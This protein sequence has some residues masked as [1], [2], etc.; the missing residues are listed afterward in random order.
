MTEDRILDEAA[1]WFARQ[2]DDAMDWE[3]FTAWLEADPCHRQAFDELCALDS[4]LYLHG[5]D[6]GSGFSDV[7]GSVSKDAGLRWGR[8]AGL[9]GAVAAA[10][11]LVVV[12]QPA[13]RGPPIQE[14]RSAA[15][16]SRQVAL[17]DGTRVALAPD[18]RLSVSGPELALEGTAYFDVPHK[19]GR[20]L[21]IRAGSF[22]IS[23]V[24]TRF[25]VANE[26]G[27]V[28]VDVA[29]GSLSV[30]S[31]RLDKAIA[32]TTGHGIKADEQTIR[33]T[34]VNPADVASWRNGRLQ[35][36]NAP[37]T[38]VVRDISRYSGRTVTVDPAVGGQPFSGVIAIDNGDTAARNLAQIMALD[39]RPVHGG[40][41]L[42][43]RHR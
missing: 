6:L 31:E 41:R 24:G 12:M 43:P 3:G 26:S 17:A 10:L 25:A 1:G 14:Y 9:G 35:F 37:L 27:S 5:K 19:P 30:S 33:L 36:E 13:E 8:W 21:A 4:D 34:Q 11:A 2:H 18:S 15:G 40:M 29:D 22:T 32:L 38:L 39:A 42:Q 20:E 7:P 28:S 23:D 16:H